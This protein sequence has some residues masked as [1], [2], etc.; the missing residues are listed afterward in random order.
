MPFLSFSFPLH[1][2]FFIFTFS[3]ISV[4][5]SSPHSFHD[6]RHSLLA[7]KNKISSDPHASMSNWSLALP[8]CNWPGVTCSRRHMDRVVSLDLSYMELQGTISPYL[9]NLSFLHYLDLSNNA[10]HGYI[11]RRLGRLFCLRKLWLHHNQLEGNL[12]SDLG[13]CTNLVSLALSY[14]NLT[15]SIPHELGSLIHLQQLY[16]AVNILTGSI[17]EELGLLINLQWLDLGENSLHGHIPSDLG[18]CTNLAHLAVTGNKLT[19][20][21]SEEFGSL[22]HLKELYL[23]AN[24]FTGYIPKFLSNISTLVDLAIFQNKFTGSIPTSLSNL[25][26]L[27]RLYL[28]GNQLSGKIPN[29]IGNC[30]KLKELILS[31]NMLSGSIPITLGKLS[32]LEE[33]YL[34]SNKLNSGSA[35]TMPF[36]IALT[37]CSHLKELDMR[38]N[39]LA[40]VLPLAIGKLSTNLSYLTLANNLIE[41]NIPPHI[42]NLTS[43][44]YLNLSGNSLNGRI[45][46][47]RNLK[48][49]ERLVLGNNKLQGDI[50]DDFENLQRL[51][52]LDISGNIL[53][54]KIPNSLAP[55]KQ[56]RFLLLHHNQLSGT[57]PSNLGNCTNLELLDLSHNK[58]IGNIPHE[59]AKL[60]NLNFY[61]NLSWNLLEGSLPTEIGKMSMAQAIDISANHLS[62]VI[63]S[64]LG[65]CVEVI[66]LNLSR[67]SFQG[68]IPDSLENLQSLMSLDLS[69]N[70]LSG[71]IP[72]TL[73]KLKMLQYLNLSF[74]KL[75][76]EIPTGGIFANESIS[77]SLNGNAN[78]CG[79]KI[80]QLYPCPTPKGQGHSTIVKRVL[81]TVGGATAFILCCF[82]LRF[83]WRGNI[84]IHNIHVS[85]SIFQKL[86]H[87]RISYQELHIATNGF[88]KANLLGTG[89]FGSVYKGILN[90]GTPVAVKVFQLQNDQ[91]EKS[92]KAE[93][94]V[95][96][97]VQHRNLAKIITSCSNLHFRALV[98]KLVSNGSL[99]KHL[100]PKRDDN[101]GEDVCQLELKTLLD[102][103]IDVAHAMEY[104][105]HDCFVQV[106]H[107]DI[108][109]SNVLLDEN[110]LGH[111]TDFEY[112]LSG[113]VSTQG[114]VYS[115]GIMLLE[116]LTRKQ[117]TNHMF[118][119]DLNLHNW[120]NFAYPNNVN[121]VIES[122]IFS[123][124]CGDEI[125]ENKVY[126]CLLDLL[127]VGLLC[128]KHS[129][130]ERPTMRV[131]VRMLES[132]KEDL[133][134]N[135]VA[136]RR[137]RRSISKLLMDA[138]AIRNDASTSNDQSSCTF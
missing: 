71:T 83:L 137:L 94:S 17:P 113:T 1:F 76:G 107:C 101:N 52:L 45:P 57:I 4:S 13:N 19:G 2:L 9:G 119:G 14:N 125:N 96:Q 77:I 12:P 59:I 43:L 10:L 111:V 72:I 33:L 15:G 106:V 110:M 51:G 126:K 80:F 60:Y 67:N 16:L 136:S 112:G 131:V 11:P 3:F 47:L 58:L 124:V 36:L 122:S 26:N 23:G 70:L 39:K 64:T 114:D 87:P 95:F 69:S 53:S 116:M 93:C 63:P 48:I 82:F 89:S 90:D 30:S 27:S 62:G 88:D 75:A 138:N 104:L 97:K 100:Y 78:L 55:L 21:V 37:N 103:A 133:E 99:E 22:I 6:D 46:S 121:E 105:H 20:S 41:G 68:S 81:L 118:V 86:E 117:P 18:N 130:E 123:E 127:H 54:G 49:L 29:S 128:S 79:P 135:A 8:F 65:S 98:F 66:S 74:N 38:D 24:S 61:L 120:V 7:F 73:N 42:G 129:P 92:F 31:E 40:G 34:H 44:T 32:L 132:I 109:P 108:K 84:H 115:Y 56:L 102:I 85:R 35:R 50:P 5:S 91:S 28:W 134:A 25:V